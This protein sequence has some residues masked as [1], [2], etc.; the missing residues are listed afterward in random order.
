MVALHKGDAEVAV[1]GAGR[2]ADVAMI[3]VTAVDGM[4][5]DG[6]SSVEGT[7]YDDRPL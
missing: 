5:L 1:G 4:G 3:F 2:E 7:Y 6:V